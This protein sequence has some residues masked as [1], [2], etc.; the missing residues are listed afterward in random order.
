MERE[1]LPGDAKG[2][3]ASSSNREAKSTEAPERAD[4]LVVVMKA[5]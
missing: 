4:C 3:G 2:K 1:N 5:L